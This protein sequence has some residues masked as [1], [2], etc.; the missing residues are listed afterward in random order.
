MTKSIS[1]RRS[2]P[3]PSSSLFLF[4]QYW[5]VQREPNYAH[6]HHK[7][8]T[9]S[10]SECEVQI[11]NLW[12][13]ACSFI[14]ASRIVNKNL[15]VSLTFLWLFW[16]EKSGLGEE[17]TVPKMLGCKIKTENLLDQRHAIRSVIKAKFF[18]LWE[19]KK[20]SLFCCMWSV[21]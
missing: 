1:I 15:K 17:V 8:K 16:Q 7:D 9:S 20:A 2:P 12:V 18:R 19:R 6:P 13:A 5:I 11:C 4:T 10:C 21:A 14:Y 3:P